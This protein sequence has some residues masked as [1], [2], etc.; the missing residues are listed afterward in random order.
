MRR[1]AQRLT[2]K[3]RARLP[4]VTAYSTATSYRMAELTRWLHAR[5]ESHKTNVQRFDE[6]LY[7]CLLYTSDAADE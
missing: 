1:D 7:T 5:R 2:R 3:A 6:C 4:R